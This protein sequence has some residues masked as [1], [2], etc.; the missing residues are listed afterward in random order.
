MKKLIVFFLLLI[1]TS[2]I[3]GQYIPMLK[4]GTEWYGYYSFEA[5]WNSSI[6]VESDTI[7]NNMK[8]KK[9]RSYNNSVYGGTDFYREDTVEQRVY[10]YGF[11]IGEDIL[12]HDF[13]LE[14]NDTFYW[15]GFPIIID[16]ITNSFFS[17]GRNYIIDLPKRTRFYYFSNGLIW[18]EGIGSLYTPIDGDYLTCHFNSEGKKDMY[19]DTLAG[20]PIVDCKG[21]IDSNK[22]I[23]KSPSILLT[24]NPS[25]G[26]IHLEVKNESVEK[27]VT[28][29]DL[30]GVKITKFSFQGIGYDL[31]ISNFPNGFYIV[32][33]SIDGSIIGLEKFVKI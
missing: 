30:T 16:S 29:Y 28:I 6:V 33:I 7:I 23:I 31:D 8:Y 19:I 17:K 32:R 15:I 25:N 9:L 10:R 12:E 3:I 5:K 4:E 21:N 20:S 14:V 1:D 11:G 22:D 18:I 13:S 26:N 24:P 27:Q 2:M